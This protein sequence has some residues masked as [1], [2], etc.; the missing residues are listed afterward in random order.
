MPTPAFL[1]SANKSKVA[2]LSIISGQVMVSEVCSYR[3]RA[4]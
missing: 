3:G 4:A 2:I 1:P